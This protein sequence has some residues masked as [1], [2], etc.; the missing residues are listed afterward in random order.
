LH[1]NV[2]VLAAMA[3][4]CQSG[5][6][7]SEPPP[8]ARDA[9]PVDAVSYPQKTTDTC[10][11][12]EPFR[13]TSR[14]PVACTTVGASCTHEDWEHGCHCTCTRFPEGSYWVCSPDTQGSICASA[15][16]GNRTPTH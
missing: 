10:F 4:A 14:E 9:A 16:A 13:I 11:P 3:V 1:A 15:P 12:N 8:R 7:R 2:I 5:G 6:P